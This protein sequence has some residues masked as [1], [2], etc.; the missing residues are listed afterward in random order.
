[1]IRAT[2]KRSMDGEDLIICVAIW[3]LYRRRL[4]LTSDDLLTIC[5]AS[6]NRLRPRPRFFASRL[7]FGAILG[8][9]GRPKWKPKSIFGRFF[10]DVFFE[11]VLASIL[12][13]FLK[14]QDLKINDFPI[15][16]LQISQNRRFRKKYEKT[17]ILESFSE[18]KTAKHRE[19]MVLKNVCFFNIDFFAFLLRFLRILAR[20]WE[21]RNP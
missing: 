1:M 17:W 12:G 9:F 20:F 3:T 16:K 7:D 10:F 14:A 2:K 11:C 18:A 21:A 19:K 15:G 13:G 5:I 8:G 6:R 4:P